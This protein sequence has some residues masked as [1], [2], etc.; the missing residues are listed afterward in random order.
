M[1]GSSLLLVLLLQSGPGLEELQRADLERIRRRPP[2]TGEAR[3]A[4][5]PVPDLDRVLPPLERRRFRLGVLAVAFADQKRP[6]TLGHLKRFQR[7]I[8]RNTGGIVDLELE[9]YGPVQVGEDRAAVSAV[10]KDSR[11]ETR[12]LGG[13]LRAS[14]GAWERADAV[15]F[16]Y[17]G[18]LSWNRAGMLWPHQNRLR[19]GDRSVPYTIAPAEGANAGAIQAHEF[20]HVFGLEDKAG[21]RR[22]ILAFGYDWLD[23][24]GA[25]RAKAGWATVGVIPS[26]ESPLKISLGDLEATGEVLRV[27]LAGGRERLYVE[28]R[29]GRL[30]VWHEHGD[31]ISCVA[32][33]DGRTRDRLT[34]YSDPSFRPKSLGSPPIFL[35]DLRIDV[36]KKR[37]YFIL[38][39]DAPLTALERARLCRR[40][41]RIGSPGH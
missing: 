30:G 13:W 20:L 5:V 10:P 38:S 17:G 34:P 15:A 22:C 33:L 18:S 39:T 24:C 28:L 2:L 7:Y 29:D 32:E 31:R 35:T 21:S 14:G 36:V 37:A 1:S 26:L 9:V 6:D 8:R 3:K 19:V 25:C 16:V 4:Y 40:G 41:E 11:R 23:V 12:I 27:D